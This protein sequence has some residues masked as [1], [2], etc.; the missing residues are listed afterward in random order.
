MNN[1]FFKNLGIG[2]QTMVNKW[3]KD[4]DPSDVACKNIIYNDG[5]GVFRVVSCSQIV[6]RNLSFYFVYGK[7]ND[8][9]VYDFENFCEIDVKIH[10]GYSLALRDKSVDEIVEILNKMDKHIVNLK[11]V[12]IQ[13]NDP[14]TPR[15]DS[16]CIERYDDGWKI[17]TYR[18][19]IWY[20][21]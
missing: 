15:L 16:W 9:I 8:H 12:Y 18:C 19:E 11:R 21:K 10:E 7:L 4:N 20:N 2:K 3:I 14:K 1:N 17:N 13:K 5:L 6:F